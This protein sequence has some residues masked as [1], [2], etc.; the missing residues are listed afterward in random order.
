MTE[1][2][3]KTD[4]GQEDDQTKS[5][6]PHLPAWAAGLAAGSAALSL[7]LLI[8]T[9]AKAALNTPRTFAPLTLLPLA[10][11]SVGGVL[12]ATGVYAL[13]CRLFR[14]PQVPLLAVTG[15]V[16][17]ASVSLPMRLF[18]SP[19]SRFA[20][21]TPALGVTLVALHTIVA[22]CSL[23]AVRFWHSDSRANSME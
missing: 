1:N 3:P 17:L 23:F 2:D 16:L 10:T 5:D 14:R 8:T 21:M 19:S 11:G 18:R 7:N 22:L 6:A 9:V 13:L 15:G 20:G 4:Q 12:G